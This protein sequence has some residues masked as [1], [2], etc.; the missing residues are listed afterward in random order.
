MPEMATKLVI[1]RAKRCMSVLGEFWQ[2]TKWGRGYELLR[3]VVHKSHLLNMFPHPKAP[4][5][6][7]DRIESKQQ[8][9]SFLWVFEPQIGEIMKMLLGV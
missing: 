5:V 4:Y 2:R 9:V 1:F 7:C 6:V 8:K 3:E